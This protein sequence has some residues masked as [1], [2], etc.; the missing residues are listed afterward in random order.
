MNMRNDDNRGNN[1]QSHGV[2]QE[3]Y[4]TNTGQAP[5]NQPRIN[6][7]EAQASAHGN[8]APHHGQYTPPSNRLFGGAQPGATRGQHE[9]SSFATQQGEYSQQGPANNQ[10]GQPPVHGVTP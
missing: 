2:P 3:P 8:E 6:E 5:Y 9:T 4:G 7:Q 1:G 10:P